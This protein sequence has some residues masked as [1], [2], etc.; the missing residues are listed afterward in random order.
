MQIFGSVYKTQHFGLLLLRMGIGLMYIGHGWPKIT[1]GTEYWINLGAAMPYW[2]IAVAPAFWGFL[3]A[4]TE[5]GGG[6]WLIL[7]LFFRPTCLMLFLTMVVATSSHI[8]NDDDFNTYSHALEMAI[9]FFSLLFIG[10][11]Q[12]SLD[13]KWQ[14][15]KFRH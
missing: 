2:G 9:V 15:T 8:N 3:A 13:A 14:S 7:G 10:P 5:F 11:G 1:G 4:I 12:Y 6:I